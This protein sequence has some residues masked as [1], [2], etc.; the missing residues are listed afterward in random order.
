MRSGSAPVIARSNEG[1]ELPPKARSRMNTVSTRERDGRRDEEPLV[2]QP[3]REVPGRDEPPRAAIGRPG[4]GG[5]HTPTTSRNSSARLGRTGPNRTTSPE[6]RARSS[7]RCSSTSAAELEHE[8]VGRRVRRAA[9]RGSSRYHP[10]SAP[11]TCT[12]KSRRSRRRSQLLDRALRHHAPVV[13]QHDP[14]AE[15]LDELELMAREHDG[16]AVV[17]GLAAQHAREHVDPDRVEPRERL[18]EHEQVGL[19][20]ERGGELHPL[21]VAE[22]QRLDPVAAALGDPERLERLP[23]ARRRASAAA[24]PCSRAR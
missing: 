2:A 4:A 9:R 19:V 14:V 22:R 12:R 13:D 18:V 3:H 6:A 1:V 23:A 15:P 17:R 10:S 24:S 21:L 7:T 5:A 20:H 11:A 8:T 16:H